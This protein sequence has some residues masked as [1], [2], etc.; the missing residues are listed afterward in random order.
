[1]SPIQFRPGAEK[2]FYRLKS[3][4]LR[5]IQDERRVSV[6][7]PAFNSETTLAIAAGSILNQSWRNLELINVDDASTDRTWPILN[8][9]ASQAQ[10]VCILRNSVNVGPYVSK[11]RAL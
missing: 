11:D 8:K 10:R 3:L 2:R 4:P 5:T 1:M 9:L 7:M 6:I